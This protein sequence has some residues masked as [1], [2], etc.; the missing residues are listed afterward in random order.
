M[1][2]YLVNFMENY[3]EKY[4]IEKYHLS[5]CAVSIFPEFNSVPAV[6]AVSYSSGDNTIEY[7]TEILDNFDLTIGGMTNKLNSCTGTDNGNGNVA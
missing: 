4:L 1:G 2:D 6:V 3:L 5:D 7:S